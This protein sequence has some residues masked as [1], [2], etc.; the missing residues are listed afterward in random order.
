MHTENG[1]II[2][3]IFYN[4]SKFSEMLRQ[5]VLEPFCKLIIIY[6]Y[7]QLVIMNLELNNGDMQ[8]ET[9]IACVDATEFLSAV[10]KLVHK[11]KNP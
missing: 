4:E 11:R 5:S 9:R 10:Y 6:M 7:N 8:T 2:E 1:F 3:F